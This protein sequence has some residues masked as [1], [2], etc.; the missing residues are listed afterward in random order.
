MILGKTSRVHESS[1]EPDTYSEDNRFWGRQVSLR[2]RI[3]MLTAGMVAVAVGMM[4]I[5]AYWTVSSALKNSV[6]R[7]LEV[8]ADAVLS[9]TLDPNF[10]Q[11]ADSELQ[12]FRQYNIGIRISLQLPGT[13][14]AIGDTIPFISASD[15]SGK[16]YAVSTVDGE[17]IFTKAND[18]GTVV[19]LARDMMYTNQLNTALGAALL[20]IGLMGAALA[21]ITGL[22]VPASGLRPLARL[23]NAV[24]RVSR[25]DELRPIEIVGND[26]LASL[27][28]SFNEM[29]EA[30]S[31]S[32][33]RQA[34]FVADAGHE[35]KTPLT[36]M[37]TNIELLIMMQRSGTGSIPEE[38]RAAIEHDVMAQ[39]EELT[40]LI[41]DLVDLAREDADGQAFEEVDLVAVTA[42]AVDRVQRRR[43]DVQFQF[44]STPWCLDGDTHGLSRAVINLLDN[45]AKW[46]PA[47]GVVRITMVPKY[48]GT[49]E[50]T[51]CDSGPGIPEEDREKVFE[52]FFR[53]VATRST[54]GSGL[55]L[56][57]VKQTIL[58]HGGTIVAGESSDGGCRMRVILPGF[59]TLEDLHRSYIGR[60]GVTDE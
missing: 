21:V 29:L 45:A 1:H 28:R 36:S 32:R 39:I 58:R 35:L 42:E 56:A 11:R 10:F 18:S 31:S 44:E 26:E 5:T 37:R 25:T 34:E 9:R 12:Y 53:G 46:S 2:W 23:Q 48:N 4:V 3:S 13:T 17:R 54:P 49:V 40:T 43:P 52:R 33:Q 30:L 47:D 7:E 57:I 24:D 19:T 20:V 50:L 55:G 16:D 38:D 14:Y 15:Q 27:T 6:D 8:K 41:G 59:S 22:M 60:N 51:V